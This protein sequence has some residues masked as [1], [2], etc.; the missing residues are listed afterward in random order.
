MNSDDLIKKLRVASS[1]LSS[2]DVDDPSVERQISMIEKIA[3]DVESLS[4]DPDSETFLKSQIETLK[5]AA[6]MPAKNYV[7]ISS[8]CAGLSRALDIASRPQYSEIR[9]RI[10]LIV[11]KVAGIFAEVDTTKDLE[12]PLEQIEKAVHSLYG[13]QSKNSNFYLERRGKG[14][15]ETSK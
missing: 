9:P 15:S 7:K 12:K 11:E 1:K 8:I 13:D 2:L 14:H 4:Q 6:D 3:G 10:A 5:N